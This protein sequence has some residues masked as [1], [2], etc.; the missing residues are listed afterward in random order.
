MGVFE[1]KTSETLYNEEKIV[2]IYLRVDENGDL[3]IMAPY[4]HL[5]TFDVSIASVNIL[6]SPIIL[7]IILCFYIDIS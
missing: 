3:K 5:F 1:I 2:A 4:V 7:K 6:R